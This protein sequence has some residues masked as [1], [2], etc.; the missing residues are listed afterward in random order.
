MKPFDK[1]GHL[2]EPFDKFGYLDS[3]IRLASFD[4]R[5]NEGLYNVFVE[6]SRR[7]MEPFDKFGHLDSSIRLAPFD[8]RQK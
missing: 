3:S 2:M 4:S 8:S 6:H 1:F 7:V 5:Q